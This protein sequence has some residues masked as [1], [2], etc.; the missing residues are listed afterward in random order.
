MKIKQLLT[1]VT[2]CVLAIGSVFS[3]S[4]CKDEPCEHVTNE[5]I[6]LWETVTPATCS[7]EGKERG[8]CQICGDVQE[9]PIA[10]DPENH[11]YGDWQVTMPTNTETGLAVK[12]C[13]YNSA[14]K[15]E[16]TLPLLT[17]TDKYTSVKITTLPTFDTPGVK[18]YVLADEEG[19]IRF[20]LPIDAR[21]VETTS[22][23]VEI[24]KQN[25]S[26]IRSGDVAVVKGTVE[27]VRAT[28]DD[29]NYITVEGE[30]NVYK[31][32]D[33]PLTSG[34][35][36]TTVTYEFGENYTHIDDN[37]DNAERWCS[38]DEN[39]ELY[40]ILSDSNNPSIHVESAPVADYML[41]YSYNF[42]RIGNIRFTGVEDMLSG[43]YT[44]G[45]TNTN[46]DFREW[47]KDND[48][49][50][51]YG[52]SFGIIA[53]SANVGNF[54]V[55]EV[56]FTLTDNCAV[57][58]LDVLA[59]T[60]VN[61]YNDNDKL[62]YESWKIDED[63]NAY[64]TDINPTVVTEERPGLGETQ[65]LHTVY[66]YT[67]HLTFTQTE[68]TEEDNVP[69][70]PYSKDKILV[71][72][73]TLRTS[74]HSETI[75][76]G[77][78]I[79]ELNAGTSYS[80]TVSVSPSTA[81]TKLDPLALYYYTDAGEFEELTIQA[82]SSSNLIGYM[83]TAGTSMT[84]T[85]TKAGEKKF[86]VRSVS[87]CETVFTV[88]FQAVAPSSV[89][90][91]IYTYYS[92]GY[93]WVKSSAATAM[94]T[95][96]V[97]KP[98]LFRMAVANSAYESAEYNAN[99]SNATNGG[100]LKAASVENGDEYSTFTA[101][102]AGTYTVRIAS[103][104]NVQKYCVISVTVKNP[105]EAYDL[106]ANRTYSGKMTGAIS[107]ITVTFKG[108]SSTDFS[109]GTA[110]LVWGTGDSETMS[111]TYADGT[112]TATYSGGMDKGFMLTFDEQYNLVVSVKTFGN[113]VESVVLLKSN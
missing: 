110:T 26:L 52:F 66:Y 74:G 90:P 57:A 22:D 78:Y 64:F 39:G 49:E 43:L 46:G 109:S 32:T 87:G 92:T 28:D 9:R 54:G 23:A 70:N 65:V 79:T 19:D 73:I 83:N 59:T 107:N 44:W 27:R 61:G 35:V 106:F 50:T 16:I 86:A 25:G 2:A 99:V 11:D 18:T 56:K 6:Y 29:G 71:H 3:F 89:Y 62:C 67:E 80:F 15:R 88:N 105:P 63:G 103:S 12:T 102:V 113:N 37:D 1:S 95:L 10:I 51:V 38:V 93:E 8:V 53:G 97:G 14:H 33:K 112:F 76:D 94:A 34:A 30:D 60:Y 104:K 31:Y 21:S 98:L 47:K 7:E 101:S 91:E 111:Y 13:S 45:A 55:F 40:V 84:I 81:N 20:T 24:G 108:V 100:D 69:V 36:S 17:E 48:G 75:V 96:Y 82:P 72:E 42:S 58:S 68:K 77:D 4:A 85:C 41:G 5:N